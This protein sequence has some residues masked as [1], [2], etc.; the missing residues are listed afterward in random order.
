MSPTA[1]ERFAAARAANPAEL[2]QSLIR[3]GNGVVIAGYFLAA[4]LRDG[5]ID[6]Y[7]L[8]TLGWMAGYEALAGAIFAWMVLR[9]QVAWARRWAAALLDMGG[10][11]LVMVRAEEVGSVMY[12]MYLWVVLGNGFRFGRRYMHGVQGIALASF[13]V[14][15]AMSDYWRRNVTLGVGLM[16]ALV[17]VPWYVS[18]L[19]ARLE[20]AR[21]AAVAANVAKT[22]YLAA[23]SHDLRQPM[24][25]LSMYASVLDERVRDAG[26]QGAVHGVQLSVKTL[27]QLFDSLLDVAQI[28]SGVVRP[29]L[30]AFALQPLVDN[31][32]AAERPLAAHKGLE[33]RVARTA[34][35]VRSDPALLERM[36][37][38]LVTNAVRYTE[39][40]GI[41]VGC[42]RAGDGR[43]RLEVV[44]SGIGIPLAERE[45]I[46]DEYYQV[47]G[48]SGQG[49][50]LG[51]PI[52]K[53]LAEL[54]GHRVSVRSAPGRG[55]AFAIELERASA[56]AVRPEPQPSRA[57]PL[58]GALVA[59][60]LG[61]ALVAIVDDDVEIRDSVRLLLAGW[62]CRTVAGASAGEVRDKLRAERRSPDALIVDYR[63]ADEST[64]PRVVE[65]LRAEFGAALPVLMITGSPNAAVLQREFAGIPVALKPVPAGKLR[66]FVSEALQRA[67]TGARA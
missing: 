13:A 33:L 20:E 37:K 59:A 23:A 6:R 27:E 56:E 67:K 26:S 5:V 38:N 18:K 28:E 9:P 14:V 58:D 19:L 43:L 64:G 1:A 42:R 8:A 55:S 16:I 52:V 53:S 41:V 30:V 47:D 51:L 35:A 4:F 22:K 39:K 32:V 29:R 57:A 63:L 60:P 15:L 65:S 54:L 11:A 12:G 2:E 25:A 31:V 62:G 61:G 40:G 7:E 45:R 48:A 10:N 34:A 3:L 24:Q 17:V 46:F 49:L 21:R 44:D 36:L 50:G 66:A